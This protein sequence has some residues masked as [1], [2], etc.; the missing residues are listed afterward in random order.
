M[1]GPFLVLK[2]DV[3]LECAKYIRNYVVDSTTLRLGTFMI[4]A[5][6]ILKQHSCA[7]CRLHTRAYGTGISVRYARN[8]R[9]QRNRTTL[10]TI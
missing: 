10:A 4:W 3:P 5:K 8:R 9:A 2:K 7:I 6:K 1:E